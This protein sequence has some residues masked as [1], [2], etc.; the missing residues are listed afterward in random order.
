MLQCPGWFTFRASII[1]MSIISRNVF[2]TLRNILRN[3]KGKRSKHG[4]GLALDI[5]EA[6]GVHQISLVDRFGNDVHI[7]THDKVIASA[8][9]RSGQYSL[10]N[11]TVFAK[12]AAEVGFEFRKLLFVDVGANIG[13]SCLNAYEIGFRHFIAIEPDPQNFSLLEKNLSNLTEG[14]IQTRQTAVGEMT[15]K[16]PLYKNPTNHGA[17]SLLRSDNTSIEID[18]VRLDQL[19]EKDRKF[20]L[21]VDVEGYEPQVIKG[22]EDLIHD[23]CQA[24]VMEL[25]PGRYSEEGRKYLEAFLRD[26]SDR[27]FLVQEGAWTKCSELTEFF[28]R[29]TKRHFDAI[30]LNRQPEPGR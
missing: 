29:D 5:L 25:S 26:F 10:E 23:Q 7:S 20:I 17:H 11:L 21:H 6:N 2:K 16:M 4:A 8:L 19:L 18:V 13:T 24:I 14:L 22:G 12:L 3:S 27:M 28:N 1:A 9:I 15:G 30:L